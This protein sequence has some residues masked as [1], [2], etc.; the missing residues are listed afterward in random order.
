MSK[1]DELILKANRVL[2][3]VGDFFPAE[4]QT[5]TDNTAIAFRWKGKKHKKYLVPVKDIAAI[6][7]DDLQCIDNQKDRIVNNTRQFLRGL[8]ANNALLWGPRGTGKSSLIKAILHAFS[9]DG[10]KMIEVDRHDLIDLP[11]IIHAIKDNQYHYVIFC[12]DLSFEAEDSSYKSLK[13]VLDGSISKT[14]DNFLVY[15]SSNRRHILPEYM[16]ENTQSGFKGEELH[17]GESVEEK[18]SLSERFGLWLS[19]HPF[20]QEEYLS[21]VDCSL[22]KFD[23]NDTSDP[24][25][26]A[27]ALRWALERGSRSGRAAW[28]FAKF[29]AGKQQLAAI[30]AHTR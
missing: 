4:P 26:R 16:Q 24:E 30:D 6:S 19:F 28:Q 25:T 3:Q 7:L 21:I 1:L 9:N 14:P 22:K 18:I 8:P 29:W 20:N 23:M 27:Q 17:L 15:A 10:L 11:E 12:D 5:E 13:V 2:D